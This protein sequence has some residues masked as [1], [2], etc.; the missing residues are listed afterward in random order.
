MC[1][2]C[3]TSVECFLRQG[4]K[5]SVCM[6]NDPPSFNNSQTPL[7]PV[8]FPNVNFHSYAPSMVYLSTNVVYSCES[9]TKWSIK[10]HQTFEQGTRWAPNKSW[11]Q[12]PEVSH[13]VMGQKHGP[14][15]P[16]SLKILGS[17]PRIWYRFWPIPIWGYLQL[18]Y[19]SR[20]F[21]E[22]NHPAPGLTLTP[23]PQAHWIGTGENPHRKPPI[24]PWRSWGGSGKP[25]NLFQQEFPYHPGIQLESARS[26]PSPGPTFHPFAHVQHHQRRMAFSRFAIGPG[27]HGRG[28]AQLVIQAHGGQAAR[29]G[30]DALGEDVN[31]LG[32]IHGVIGW[33]M[34]VY[35]YIYIKFHEIS[36]PGRSSHHVQKYKI[37]RLRG[38]A[39]YFLGGQKFPYGGRNKIPSS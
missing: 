37:L 2:I 8:L 6:W 4:A 15:V 7:F 27:R 21:H 12:S 18:I 20:S 17:S 14:L 22:G 32:R 39:W 26:P 10:H 3:R 19:F 29:P 34:C 38:F 13:L 23:H 36:V 5:P 25:F 16:Y 9:W 28:P 1:S 24:F 33:S 11:V 35:I 30:I 31:D